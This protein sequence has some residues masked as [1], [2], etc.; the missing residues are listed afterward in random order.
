MLANHLQKTEQK[1]VLV[2]LVA[3]GDVGPYNNR[4]PVTVLT[5]RFAAESEGLGEMLKN[6]EKT[7]IPGV[8]QQVDAGVYAAL[9]S[10]DW[11]PDPAC[12]RLLVVCGNAPPYEE[13][14]GSRR[15]TTD[16][17]V[18]LARQRR[19]TIL[20]MLAASQENTDVREQMRSFLLQL[21]G[22]TGGR[23]ADLGS[24][25]YCNHWTWGE[26]RFEPITR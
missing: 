24:K 14:A 6:V 12:R 8:N 4:K 7:G 1:S 20:G 26:R 17:L 22:R 15:H 18:R 21:C 19:V 5:P 9:D 11:N 23:M 2:A 25:S 13:G 10:L 16:E 3:Y